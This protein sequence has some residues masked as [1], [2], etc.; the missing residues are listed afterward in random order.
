MAREST[1]GLVNLVVT[2]VVVLT[3]AVARAPEPGMVSAAPVQEQLDPL[4][5][6][7]GDDFFEAGMQYTLA[8]IGARPGTRPH[9]SEVGAERHQALPPRRREGRLVCSSRG[10]PLPLALSVRG[11]VVPYMLKSRLPARGVVRR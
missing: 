5:A 3:R 7:R 4:L 8:G 11:T 9:R 1:Y 10:K 6:Q 2:A